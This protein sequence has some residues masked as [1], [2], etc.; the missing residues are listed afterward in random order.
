MVIQSIAVVIAVPNGVIM[1]GCLG[2]SYCP[3]LNAG[4]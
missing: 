2:V 1:A 4:K 3:P